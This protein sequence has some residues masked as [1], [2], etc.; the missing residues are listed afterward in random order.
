MLEEKAIET[1]N[2]CDMDFDMYLDD[3]SLAKKILASADKNGG[4]ISDAGIV[5]VLRN[6]L[7]MLIFKFYTPHQ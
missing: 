3:V 6:I 2:A 5:F 1:E 7:K 4:K